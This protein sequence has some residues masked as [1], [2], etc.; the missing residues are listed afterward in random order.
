LSQPI[1][2]RFSAQ[3]NLSKL[4]MMFDPIGY[5]NKEMDKKKQIQQGHE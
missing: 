1:N 5:L 3:E 4:D 2:G